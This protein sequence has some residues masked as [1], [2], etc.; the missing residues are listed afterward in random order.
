MGRSDLRNEVMTDLRLWSPLEFPSR[1]GCR[2]LVRRWSNLSSL[3]LNNFHTGWYSI[4]RE[5]ENSWIAEWCHIESTISKVAIWSDTI[6]NR[7]QLF[8]DSKN[9]IIPSWLQ[10]KEPSQVQENT[11]HK[12]RYRQSSSLFPHMICSS[13]LEPMHSAMVVLH[14]GQSTFSSDVQWS[15]SSEPIHI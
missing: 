4:S 6:S 8:G 14:I 9:R 15:K 2:L 11:S 5:V 10:W 7:C 3:P 1:S 12:W 13:H